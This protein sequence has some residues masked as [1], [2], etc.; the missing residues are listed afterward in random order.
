[1]SA[2]DCSWGKIWDMQAAWVNMWFGL[3]SALWVDWI[4]LPSGRMNLGAFVFGCL[5]IHG[6]FTLTWF[7]VAP[8]SSMPYCS[9]LVGGLPL[10]VVLFLLKFAKFSKL[11]SLLVTFKVLVSDPNF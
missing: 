8:V 9:R 4:M 10:H 5:L 6:L 1:M 3:S 2:P 7:C 11:S